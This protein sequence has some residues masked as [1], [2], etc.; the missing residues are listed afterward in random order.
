[1]RL[2]DKRPGA[3]AGV[4]KVSL[5]ATL[6]LFGATCLA[7]S[8]FSFTVRAA[9]EGGFAQGSDTAEHPDF[10]GRWNL[11]KSSSNLP[12]PSPEDLVETIDH[13]DPQLRI[14]TS[15]KD[16]GPSE[17]IAK[18]LFALM[19]PEVSTT[20]D[21]RENTAK[22]G[23]GELKSKTRW[24]GKSLVTEWGLERDGQSE[25]E[26][27]WARSLSADGKTLTL[28]VVAGEP[29]GGMQGTAKLVFVKET[30][31]GG[32]LK[33]FAG[34]WQAKF[35]GVTYIVVSL[36]AA[37]DGK[38]EFQGKEYALAK[39]GEGLVGSVSLGNFGVDEHGQVNHVENE[40]NPDYAQ[41][42]TSSRIE[43]DTL[44]LST[45]NKKGVEQLF[46]M[47]I[48]GDGEAKLKWSPPESNS[49]G[50]EPGWWTIT[51][52]LARAENE[53]TPG[54]PSA[55]VVGGVPGGVSGGVPGRTRTIEGEVKGSPPGTVSQVS[56]AGTVGGTVSGTVEDP[57]GGR[58]TNAVVSLI[59]R[60]GG[61]DGTVAT[62]ENGRFLI[63][64]VPP[65]SYRLV[66][67]YPNFERAEATVKVP[68]A[69]KEVHVNVITSPSNVV[70]SAIVTAKGPGGGARK[71]AA[72]VPAR[73]HMGGELAQ[74]KAIYRPQPQYPDSASS[75]GI[76]GTVVLEAVISTEGVP[77]SV[78]VLRS[79]DPGL[80]DSAVAAV[81]QWRFEPTKLNGVPVEVV[82][83]ITVRFT[84]ED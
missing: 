70:E 47:K 82:T 49:F 31:A 38:A 54:G 3:S 75:K 33:S 10:S 39:A 16:W 65:G 41:P 51:R 27:T 5:L 36:R 2:L 48:A 6:A 67:R 15:S 26:G 25:M 77:L 4:V 32:S 57:S 7:A 59:G 56:G 81:K 46:Q 14:G 78:N 72:T 12:S 63:D 34:A 84:L 37:D 62:D 58:L 28:R 71:P 69:E 11:D 68:G 66:V 50:P 74:A 80:T 23:P 18:T 52:T 8:V 19:I 20:T 83:D 45:R 42:I 17:P 13:R 30:S 79:P 9:P 53:E 76:E 60:A 1:M 22:F 43:G 29:G 55:G 24:E 44:S 40:P 21:N 64:H 35:E 61:F 73:V